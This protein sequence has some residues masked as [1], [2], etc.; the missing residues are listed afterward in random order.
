[1]ITEILERNFNVGSKSV[2]REIEMCL[3]S[4]EKMFSDMERSENKFKL[5]FNEQSYNFILT[6]K[7]ELC[8]LLNYPDEL[9]VNT[10]IYSNKYIPLFKQ[11]VTVLG[12]S[13][14]SDLLV[15]YYMEVLSNETHTIPNSDILMPGV[16]S[17]KAFNDFGKKI[18]NRYLFYMYIRSDKYKNLN[19]KDKDSYTI[20]EYIESVKDE[21]EDIYNAD[22]SYAMLGGYFV[23]NLVTVNLL[24]QVLVKHPVNQG[25]T[26]NLLR[27]T[28]DSREI[29]IRDKV[30]IY[31]LPPKLPMVCEPDKYVY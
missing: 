23:W 17:T 30:K 3:H 22:A 2:Q 31:H 1:M 7:Q 25:E 29:L 8:N 24:Y 13:V 6:K 10:K 28:Q 15:S 26:I 4:Q 21:Y 16:M 18:F 12:S 27:I 14:V 20:S 5:N 11:I 9:V 19:K